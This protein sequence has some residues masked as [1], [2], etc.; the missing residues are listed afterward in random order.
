[1]KS[2]LP[3]L[4]L[5][6][7]ISTSNVQAQL[8]PVNGVLDGEQFKRVNN[9]LQELGSAPSGSGGKLI[10]A[11]LDS[12]SNLS[13][14][15]LYQVYQQ[16]K[17]LLTEPAVLDALVQELKGSRAEM[18]SNLLFH[19]RQY[20]SY[21]LNLEQ[22]QEVTAG[23]ASENALVRENLA[24]LLNSVTT[25]GDSGV[26]PALIKVLISDP[27]SKV[28]MTAAQSLGN[29][30]REVYFKNSEAIALAL[31]KALS[32]D[33]SPQVRSNAASGLA[34]MGGKAA[35]AAP[36]L[37]VALTDNSSMV[38]S[39][40]LQSVINIGSPCAA[41]V[42]ELIDMLKAPNDPYLGSSKHRVLQAL[43]AIGPAASKAMPQ[44]LPL[45]QEKNNASYA[46]GALAAFG[47][48]ALPAVP[49]LAKLLD[50]PFSE[51]REAAARALGGIGPKARSALAAL[52][53][54]ASDER[55]VQGYGNARA[56]K[57]AALEAIARI[58]GES[59]NFSSDN[60]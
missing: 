10:P 33:P 24:H 23:F 56:S 26:Q 49:Q 43:A 25:A 46:A 12:F 36:I 37:R 50:S 45:L 5:S 15:Q 38:R 1:M 17:G 51:E 7:L 54:A 16:M 53:K 57:Q 14:S 44:I 9:I 41:C 60:N 59:P 30:G 18:A 22:I 48:S 20:G 39:Q 35:P 6:L 11:L 55:N 32:D 3:L 42:D 34:Q 8:V 52:R 31:A 2:P 13:Q 19:C 27:S 40:V 29:L 47:E 4:L 28:R 21:D 58:L